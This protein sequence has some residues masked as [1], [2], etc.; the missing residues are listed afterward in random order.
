MHLCQV[1]KIIEYR[2]GLIWKITYFFVIFS[3]VII[4]GPSIIGIYK[5]YSP[6]L[7]TTLFDMVYSDCRAQ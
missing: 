7:S 6:H 4:F 1:N 2:I 5:K 3:S